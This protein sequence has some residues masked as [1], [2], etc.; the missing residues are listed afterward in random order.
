MSYVKSVLRKTWGSALA[1]CT[2][3]W[4]KLSIEG[5]RPKEGETCRNKE[6]MKD[7]MI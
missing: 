6:F 5:M 4:E 7:A 2:K 3:M 1:E